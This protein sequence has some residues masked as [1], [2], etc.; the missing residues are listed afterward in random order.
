[1]ECRKPRIVYSEKILTQDQKSILEDIGVDKT[2]SYSCGGNF[3]T[4]DLYVDANLYCT[5]PV[6][7]AYYRKSMGPT[8]CYN[9]AQTID[10]PEILAEAAELLLK[11]SVVKP[12]CKNGCPDHYCS[13]P[14]RV[15]T[16]ATDRLKKRK[17]MKRVNAASPRKRAKRLRTAGIPEV[18][19][20]L[21]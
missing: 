8:V 19:V 13:R 9:C 21:F 12:S 7:A 18:N 11:Y 1:M 15:V 4:R 14:K 16:K 3:N 17:R 5:K 10:A 20:L 2:L 6:A